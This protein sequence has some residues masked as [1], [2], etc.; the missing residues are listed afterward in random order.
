MRRMSI[1]RKLNSAS[2][3]T[4]FG[5]RKYEENEFWKIA[6]VEFKIFVSQALKV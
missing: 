4:G 5:L 2:F 3:D 1:D 6:W